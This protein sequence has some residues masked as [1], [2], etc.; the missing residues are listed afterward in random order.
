MRE[1]FA[2][3]EKGK[4]YA[5]HQLPIE[6]GVRLTL[7]RQEIEGVQTLALLPELSYAR[8]GEEGYYVLPR[9]ISHNGDHQIFFREREDAVLK[10]S[11]A[12]MCFYG[13]KKKDMCLL[14]RFNRTRHF[15][16]VAELKD[17]VYSAYVFFDFRPNCQKTYTLH[18]ELY[19]DIVMEV[20]D[21]PLSAG[22]EEM[23]A[24]ERDIRLSRG[25]IIPLKEKCRRP[26]VEYARQYPLIRI[27]MGWKPSPS[28][29]KH[30][31]PETEPEMFVA[32]T[33][34]QVCRIGDELKRQGV[35]GA[36]LQLVGWNQ[37]GHDGRFPQ[38]FPVDERL[39]GEEGLRRA[40]D[41]IKSLGYRISLH[42]NLI[43]EYEVAESYTP[44]DLA[45]MR[46]GQFLQNGH[47]SGGLAYH[48]C[49]LKQLKN[50]K[51]EFPRIAA[52]GENGLH[53]T[54]VISIVQPDPCASEAHP[55]HTEDGIVVAERTMSYIRNLFGGFS[56][57][58]TMDFAIKYID[59]GLYVTF[60]DGF[61]HTAT[62]LSDRYLP[63]FQLT[64]HGTLLYNPSSP[65]IN[66]PI[67]RPEDR[68]TFYMHG[69]R[70]SFY[71]YSKFR[72]GGQANWMGDAD[73]TCGTEE[74]LRQSCAVIA[75]GAAEY[76][77]LAR[78]QT[79]YMTGYAFLTDTLQCATYEDGT[80]MVGNFSP[81]TVEFEGHCI[82]AYEFLV[83]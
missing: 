77:P 73:L 54:D 28:P 36:E 70:P 83:I 72:T 53:F 15:D 46:N 29:V 17:G 35:E 14:V 61:G 9:N 16:I 49:P 26:A 52:L 42:T 25:E 60:G 20:I 55:C 13:I 12:I 48:V 81:D 10:Y 43:D 33:F 32:C 58:G 51:R 18:E 37:S 30:Q 21:L 64:Y 47:Y 62:P 11:R 67:K 79:L 66:Y 82:P 63:L 45:I 68:L 40:I 6:G 50:A 22:Y 24:K 76:A 1:Y 75:R 3:D 41:H 44:E 39:G 59:Y 8:A 34:E 38:F 19:E 80:R 31:T 65:T 4:K 74:E 2:I 7:Y 78:L 23:A 57:E 71:F 69:G 27:R 56:S 5:F